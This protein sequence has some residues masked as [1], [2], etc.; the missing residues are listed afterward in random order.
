MEVIPMAQTLAPHETLELHELLNA[1]TVCLT[2]DKAR[3]QLV[4]DPALKSLIQQDIQKATGSIQ[5]MQNILSTSAT[6]FN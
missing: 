3:L 2:E 4:Q 6:K 1:K 5:Q